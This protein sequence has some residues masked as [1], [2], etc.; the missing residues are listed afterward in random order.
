MFFFEVVKNQFVSI[1]SHRKR[2]QGSSSNLFSVTKL[3]VKLRVP[4]DSLPKG[5]V[6]TGAVGAFSPTDF[7][8][9]VQCTRPQGNISTMDCKSR[10]NLGICGPKG[11]FCTSPV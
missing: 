5:L 1:F 11:T 4:K 10:K 7:W 9:R 3:S 6:S 2:S 8:Q